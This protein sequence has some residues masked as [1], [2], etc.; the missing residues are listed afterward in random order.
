MISQDLKKVYGEP[1]PEA[2]SPR[3]QKLVSVGDI[4]AAHEKA[5]TKAERESILKAI[6]VRD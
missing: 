5:K 6:E 4:I 2:N 3:K 1:K